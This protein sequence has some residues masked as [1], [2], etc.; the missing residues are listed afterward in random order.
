MPKNNQTF[1]MKVPLIRMFL[2]RKVPLIELHQYES[3]PDT[4]PKGLIN[5]PTLENKLKAPLRSES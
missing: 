3:N 4:E 5:L 1:V 2:F